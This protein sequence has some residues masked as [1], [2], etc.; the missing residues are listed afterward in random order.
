M[1]IP[2]LRQVKE[3]ILPKPTPVGDKFRYDLIKV[4]EEALREIIT[5][6]NYGGYASGGGA[7]IHPQIVLVATGAGGDFQ[8]LSTALASIT[9]SSITKPYIVLTEPGS[10]QITSSTAM[11]T[12]TDIVSL[13]YGNVEIYGN[14]STYLFGVSGVNSFHNCKIYNTNHTA[15][16][17]LFSFNGN[18]TLRFYNCEIG[19]PEILFGDAG[20]YSYIYMNDSRI[21]ASMHNRY[22]IYATTGSTQLYFNGNCYSKTDNALGDAYSIYIS[23]TGTGKIYFNGEYTEFNGADEGYLNNVY[24]TNNTSNGTYYVNGTVKFVGFFNYL[25]YKSALEPDRDLIKLQPLPFTTGLL[26]HLISGT[27]GGYKSIYAAQADWQTFNMFNFLIDHS[28]TDM[29]ER[30][31]IYETDGS[32]NYCYMFE[33]DFHA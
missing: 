2:V 31:C 21:D 12:Y 16:S 14:I 33:D 19:T 27:Y 29:D 7:L 15:N 5:K 6:L 32:G 11:P 20:Y 13:G 3:Y 28:S 8:D 17:K 1:S 22:L 4:L 10:Y 30:A 25:Q 26:A 23:S 9:D 24:I 18:S